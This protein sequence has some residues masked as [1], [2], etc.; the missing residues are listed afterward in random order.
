MFYIDPLSTNFRDNP[1][2][3]DSDRDFEVGLLKVRQ[4]AID[5][6]LRGELPPGDLLDLLESQQIDPVEYMDAATA[7]IESV[8]NR[9]MEIEGWDFNTI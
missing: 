1:D 7:A 8:I 9:G 4:R 5:E 3:N 2:F 6:V